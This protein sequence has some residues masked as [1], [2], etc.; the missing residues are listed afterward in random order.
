MV[1]EELKNDVRAFI[2]EYDG[3]T[4]TEAAL[5]LAKKARKHLPIV[6]LVASELP[7]HWRK[8]LLQELLR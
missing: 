3:F 6:L 1:T 7:S 5:R 8:R 2:S 4:V